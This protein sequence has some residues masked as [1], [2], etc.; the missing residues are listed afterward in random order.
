METYR[1]GHNE[2]HSKCVS[3]PG[4]EGSNPSVSAKFEILKALYYGLS[5][6]FQYSC[7]D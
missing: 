7:F 5:G 4:L 6:F 1:S 2:A 3:P